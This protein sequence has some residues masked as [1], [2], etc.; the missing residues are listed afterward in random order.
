MLTKLT[1]HNF[2]QFDRVEIELG[3]PVVFIGSNN[4]GK[5]TALQ[6]LTLWEI[7]LR[8]WLEK[9]GD[10]TTASQRFGVTLNRRDLL[11]VPVPTANLL[12]HDLHV[13]NQGKQRSESIRIKIIVDGVTDGQP[14][15]CGL[16]FDFANQ[17]SLY[18][19][20]LRLEET[21]NPQR[22]PLPEQARSLRIAYLQPMSGLAANE[23]RLFNGAIQVRIGEGRTAEV[24]RNLC[25][26][27]WAGER[28]A[29]RWQE[30]VDQIA[31]LFGFHLDEPRDIPERGEIEMS[32]RNQ[33]GIR[34]ELSASGRGFQQTL[35]LLVYIPANPGAILLLDE[36]DAHLEILRQRQ[37]Y[38]ALTDIATKQ[39]NQI[40]AASHSEVI[41]NEAADRDV[42]VAFVGKPHRIDDRGEQ[43]LKS[44][45]EIGFDQYYQ[46]ETTGWVLYL[47]GATDLAI[48]RRFAEL[49]KH[50]AREVLEAPFVHYVFNQP[51]KA[52]DH[53]YGLREAKADLRGFALYD[54]LDRPL[55]APSALRE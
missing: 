46:A 50:S 29:E 47:E 55:P 52:R 21:A 20:P 9:R 53:F 7:G 1:I 10:A 44:L 33:Q 49:L 34:L 3:N 38:Q 35:L 17:E 14:W 28:G 24:V 6:A 22:M 2:K 26:Q 25:Y 32:Y 41:L 23:T 45:K 19:R 8:R 39:G 43:L 11:A 4:S 42:V 36:P 51:V 16:E 48:L 5:T 40:I 12:W 15:Q 18:C 54:R 27:I 13:R 30:I 37:I 31:H